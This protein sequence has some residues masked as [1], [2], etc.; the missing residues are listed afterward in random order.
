MSELLCPIVS[1]ID[2]GAFTNRVYGLLAHMLVGTAQVFCDIV[3]VDCVTTY[4][5]TEHF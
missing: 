5:G 4:H 3:S 1:G 2:S